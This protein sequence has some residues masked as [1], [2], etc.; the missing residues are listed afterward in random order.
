[1]YISERRSMAGTRMPLTQ[2]DSGKKRKRRASDTAGES[3]TKRPRVEC[4]IP[5]CAPGITASSERTHCKL[6]FV[7]VLLDDSMHA[8]DDHLAES[9]CAKSALETLPEGVFGLVLE[10]ATAGSVIALL[11][12]SK[13]IARRVMNEGTWGRIMDHIIAM[14]SFENDTARDSTRLMGKRDAVKR[15]IDASANE[16]AILLAVAMSSHLHSRVRRI[17]LNAFA[18]ANLASAELGHSHPLSKTTMAFGGV[19][20]HLTLSEVGSAHA[21]LVEAERAS[22]RVLAIMKSS[23]KLRTTAST[24]SGK[25]EMIAITRLA[26]NLCM[27]MCATYIKDYPSAFRNTRVGSVVCQRDLASRCRLLA[28]AVGAYNNLDNQT[29]W[30]GFCAIKNTHLR[31]KLLGSVDSLRRQEGDGAH[32]WALCPGETSHAFLETLCGNKHEMVPGVAFHIFSNKSSFLESSRLNNVHY[33]SAILDVDTDF[34]VNLLD[35]LYFTLTQK[36]V[37][38]LMYK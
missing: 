9:A 7:K 28:D 4:V 29:D 20:A 3:P 2:S 1:M 37:M 8:A 26:G 17:P 15:F 30:E 33:R 21:C 5:I 36:P 38:G 6:D 22:T 31:N 35:N 13:T 32:T 12:T 18:Y 27:V 24:L 23:A 25:H 10:H 16:E 11:A 19:F 34:L 14:R